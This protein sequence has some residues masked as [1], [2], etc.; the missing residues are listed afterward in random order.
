VRP[1]CQLKV[2][3]IPFD[4]PSERV[5][6]TFRSRQLF[7]RYRIRYAAARDV[8]SPS[9]LFRSSS[10][11]PRTRAIRNCAMA[12]ELSCV[13]LFVPSSV[14]RYKG[15][16]DRRITARARARAVRKAQPGRDIDAIGDRE[17]SETRVL[18]SRNLFSS[19]MPIATTHPLAPRRLIAELPRGRFI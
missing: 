19:Y 13:A 10:A 14:E 7:P 3:V 9:P 16:L 4:A 12:R 5:S 2:S 1:T 8:P 6:S 17:P 15:L 11:A 18:H